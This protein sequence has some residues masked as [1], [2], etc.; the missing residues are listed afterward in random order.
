MLERH[1]CQ[2]KEQICKNIAHK[3]LLVEQVSKA[4]IFNLQQIKELQ[5]YVQILKEAGMD[6]DNHITEE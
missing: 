6:P 2:T 4:F 5:R 3:P 1:Y